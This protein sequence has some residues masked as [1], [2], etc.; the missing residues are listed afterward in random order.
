MTRIDDHLLEAHRR[1]VAGIDIGG[2][3]FVRF[4][5]F[6]VEIDGQEI[7]ETLE[8]VGEVVRER[9]EGRDDGRQRRHDALVGVDQLAAD[10]R[11]V[12]LVDR[13]ARVN[14]G[15][16][17]RLPV[18]LRDGHSHVFDLETVAENP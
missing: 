7:G 5:L 14:V 18:Q 2:T 10:R 6:V 4:G 11:K 8:I 16:F 15:E 17:D 3:G 12:V 1:R 9:V 13:L